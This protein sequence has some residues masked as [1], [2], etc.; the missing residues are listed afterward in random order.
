VRESHVIWPPRSYL[1]DVQPK[2]PTI[3]GALDR[4]FSWFDDA[5]TTKTSLTVVYNW[6]KLFL[7][8]NLA[9]SKSMLK[10]SWFWELVVL[11]EIYYLRDRKYERSLVT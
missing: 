4:R 1:N 6:D 3:E 7:N 8:R 10:D 2:L 11:G 5:K 9:R